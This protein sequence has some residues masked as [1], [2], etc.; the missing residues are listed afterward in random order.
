MHADTTKF[1]LALFSVPGQ[2]IP[3]KTGIIGSGATRF[4]TTQTPS[5]PP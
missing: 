2:P 1:M 5:Y 3:W 4:V